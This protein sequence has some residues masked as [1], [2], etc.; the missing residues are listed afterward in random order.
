MGAEKSPGKAVTPRAP[1]ARASGAE[2]AGQSLFWCMAGAGFVLSLVGCATDGTGGGEQSFN[3]RMEAFSARLSRSVDPA[4][5]SFT[6]VATPY[7]QRL[8]SNMEDA[9]KR[10]QKYIANRELL[11]NNKDAG[12]HNESSLL[13]LLKRVGVADDA[14]SA[15]RATPGTGAAPPK[16]PLPGN[17]TGEWRWPVDAGIITSHFGARWGK[18]HRGMDIAADVGEPVIAMAD[19]E[20]VYSDNKMRGYGN[21]IVI[22][23]ANNMT[24]LYAHNDQLIADVGDKVSKGTVVSLLGNTGRS[25]GPHVHFEIRQGKD[26]LDPY[27][28]LP[29]TSLLVAE[30]AI[31]SPRGLAGPYPSSMRFAPGDHDHTACEHA[32]MEP[33][34]A[35]LLDRLEADGTGSGQDLAQASVP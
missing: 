12:L 15:D 19:G 17:A 35:E 18:Q 25:T 4:V 23:H 32:P 2:R 22:K 14:G 21:V 13:A 11:K 6:E 3:Q 31:D 26:A 20:V 27:A 5:K 1:D 16:A 10:M 8:A 24:S 30:A 33:V 28:L 34:L 7:A 9:G 29:A